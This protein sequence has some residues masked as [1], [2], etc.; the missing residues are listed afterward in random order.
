MKRT[1]VQTKS[2]SVMI[3]KG[4]TIS[5]AITILL[6]AGAATLLYAGTITDSRII[7][8]SYV[9]MFL[10]IYIGIMFSVKNLESHAAIVGAAVAAGYLLTQIALNIIIFSGNFNLLWMRV[11]IAIVAGVLA[12]LTPIQGRKRKAYRYFQKCQFVQFNQIGK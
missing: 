8:V 2:I 9:I 12:V 10:A 1:N 3:I 4:L 5:C 11:T 7:T 6:I